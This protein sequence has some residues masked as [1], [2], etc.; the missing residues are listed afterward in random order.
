MNVIGLFFFFLTMTTS[1]VLSTLNINE[2]T[3]LPWQP[4]VRNALRN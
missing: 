2:V 4:L 1:Q 3:S